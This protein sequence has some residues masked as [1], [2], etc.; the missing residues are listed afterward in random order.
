[1]SSST[2]NKRVA[3]NTLFLY[4]RMILIMLVSLYTSRVIL[5]TLG[6]RD[7][8][9]YNV[10]AGVVT[11]FSFLNN[12]MST[13]TQRFLTFELGKGDTNGLKKVFA[14]ALNIHI[15]IAL[16]VIVLA[17]TVGLWFVNAKLVIPAD[18]MVAA[19]WIYQF[20]I[21]S[22]CVNVLQVPYNATL[23]AH[24]KMSIYAYISILE[25]LLKLG[26]VYLL[27]ISPIDKLITYGFLFL[28]VQILIRAI[29]QVYCRRHYEETKFHLFWDKGLYKQMSGFAGWNLFGS[30]AWLLRDQGLNIVLNLFFGP[31][32]NAARGVSY[33][34][35]NAVVNFISN[36]QVALNPQITKNY[37][38]GSYG[39][40]EKLAYQGIKFSFL[41]LFMMAFPLCIDIKFVLSIWLVKVPDYTALFII[42]I[43]IDALVGNLFGTPF[44]T[45]LS[46]TGKIRNYQITVSCIILLIVPV[47]YV[48]LKL[49][50]GPESVF[51]V[52]ILFNL[53]SGMARYAFCIKQIGYSAKRYVSYV[54]L[55]L[56]GVVIVSLP[57]PLI[58]K[59]YLENQLS[60]LLEFLSLCVISFAFAFVASWFIGFS[61]HER[62]MIVETV[63]KK[64]HH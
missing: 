28:M 29:Y 7:Y 49:G 59:Y 2:N 21:L 5:A 37:A 50:A 16:L 62:E 1:M 11:M 23:I 55:P 12:S 3:K 20:A 32:I 52:A 42:L 8:G 35:S 57:I 30:I 6:I 26:I 61:K 19:N 46:A 36:F 13:A 41:L 58:T 45:S 25:V 56:T 64:I 4:F 9:I 27:V 53:I 43:L 44:M 63:R 60:G 14:V 47:S 34:V 15:C 31:V 10:V 54:I 17:E 40:M 22:F 51:Y 38:N 39:E 48:I 24:E 18:R 33:Q